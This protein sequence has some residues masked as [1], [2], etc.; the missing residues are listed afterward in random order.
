MKRNSLLEHLDYMGVEAKLYIKGKDRYVTK[1]GSLMTIL[2]FISV[3]VISSFFIKYWVEKVD[4]NVLFMK[5]NSDEEFFMDLN[6]KPFFFRL[7]DINVKEVDPRLVSLTLL[8]FYVTPGKTSFENTGLERCTIQKHLPDTKFKKM[9]ENIDYEA[10]YCM[11]N[12]KQDLNITLN[13]KLKT[14]SY[15]N[16]YVHECNNSTM[17]ITPA[18]RE[19]Q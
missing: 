12:D 3:I 15:Y 2:S 19:R 17:N 13:E 6:F 9:L 18:I 4:V 1:L 5:E 11:K 8:K 14:K 10:C 7:A 16:L